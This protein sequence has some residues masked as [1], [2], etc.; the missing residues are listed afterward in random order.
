[1]DLE[2]AKSERRG[3]PEGEKRAWRGRQEKPPWRKQ[4]REHSNSEIGQEIS[5]NSQD[6]RFLLYGRTPR[7]E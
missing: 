3:N 5:G 2:F 4:Q 6:S 7:E 1:M